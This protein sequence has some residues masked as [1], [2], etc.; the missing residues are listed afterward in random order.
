MT[1]YEIEILNVNGMRSREKRA[2]IFET[3]NFL[4]ANIIMMQETCSA[5]R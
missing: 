3:L 5:L 1:G 2:Q 4:N